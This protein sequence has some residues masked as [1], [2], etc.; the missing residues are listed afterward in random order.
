MNSPKLAVPGYKHV[1]LLCP[2]L[3]QGGGRSGWRLGKNP[4]LLHLVRSSLPQP[5]DLLQLFSLSSYHFAA[6]H[7]FVKMLLIDEHII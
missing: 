3:K 6:Q 1:V 4:H 7:V 5:H 2:D